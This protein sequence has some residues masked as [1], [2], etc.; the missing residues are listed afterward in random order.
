M[1]ELN[2][3]R[4]IYIFFAEIRS[5]FF[6]TSFIVFVFCQLPIANCQLQILRGS[7]DQSKAVYSR[8]EQK[9]P[10]RSRNHNEVIDIEDL[11]SDHES[12]E[13]PS[14][15]E[16]VSKKGSDGRTFVK[17]ED[18]DSDDDS[19][20]ESSIEGDDRSKRRKSS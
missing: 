19:Q 9:R 20:E 7:D 14:I 1:N 17:M 18:L 16:R 3:F 8:Q 6:P 12:E 4:L 5:C 10:T 2:Q 11:D 13:V 15:E